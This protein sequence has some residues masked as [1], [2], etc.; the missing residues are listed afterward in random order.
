VNRWKEQLEASVVPPDDESR[1]EA[2]GLK[3]YST[4]FQAMNKL[5]MVATVKMHLE[6]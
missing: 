1:L 4:A 6:A 5:T 2:I 3:F